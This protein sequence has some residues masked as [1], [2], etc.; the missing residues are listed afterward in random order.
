MANKVSMVPSGRFAQFLRQGVER[1]GISLSELA[2]RIDYS[3]EQMRKLWQGKSSPSPLL[4]KELS[5]Q[6]DIDLKTAQ[7]AVAADRA[8]RAFPGVEIGTSDA[9]LAPLTAVAGLLDER[10]LATLITVAQGLVAGRKMA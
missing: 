6:L 8:A 10:E 7:A 5:K 2:S 3:Y 1:K 4:V 9:R